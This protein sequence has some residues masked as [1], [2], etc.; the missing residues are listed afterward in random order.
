MAQWKTLTPPQGPWPIGPFQ[1]LGPNI[2]NSLIPCVNITAAPFNAD[3]SG[4]TDSLPAFT[5]L[6]ATYP[7]G[8]VRVCIP[9]GDYNVSA[10]VTFHGHRWNIEG[11]GLQ[12]TNI[13]F[14]GSGFIFHNGAGSGDQNALKDLTIFSPDV[15]NAK[16]ALTLIDQRYFQLRNIQVAGGAIGFGVTGNWHDNTK[17][18]IAIR[19]AGRDW[20]RFD[21][22]S[23]YAD[24]PWQIDVNPNIPDS[25]EDLDTCMFTNCGF[26]GE[27][28]SAAI[29]ACIRVGDHSAP[30]RIT[31]DNVNC[32][33]G[34]KAFEAIGTP[35]LTNPF[36]WNFRQFH[37][38]QQ[39]LAANSWAFDINQTVNAYFEQC[40]SA[41]DHANGWKLR[42]TERITFDE[43]AVL[44]SGVALD[45]DGTNNYVEWRD[46]YY[47]STTSHVI[48]GMTEL[49]HYPPPVYDPNSLPLTAK[50]EKATQT[51]KGIVTYGR[52]L[53]D[54]TKLQ[55]VVATSD[56][57]TMTLAAAGFDHATGTVELNVRSNNGV[58]VYVFNQIW[59]YS[60]VIKN[61][62]AAIDYETF[63]NATN[64]A[65]SEVGSTPGSFAPLLA[66][67]VSV[68]AN[69]FTFSAQMTNNVGVQSSATINGRITCDSS[70]V[71]IAL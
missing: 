50:Y 37:Y 68:I 22:V 55:T 43:C 11:S 63:V 57:F 30:S 26:A 42:G 8:Q 34:T 14:N 33:G 67:V 65:G 44:G 25:A 64:T 51:V 59:T 32:A 41:G 2:F 23:C 66:F 38:E 49:K 58:D 54:N 19:T 4:S 71:V 40:V 10:P 31:L 69:V 28:T 12:I 39:P 36:D 20:Y 16:T 7:N 70:K 24:I 9:K 21:N 3:P 15:A 60:I 17:T 45:F 1:N 46:T 5:Q 18:S 53:V 35:G 13:Y 62:T 47:Q 56:L 48:A 6:L 27:L 29:N 52:R 61:G